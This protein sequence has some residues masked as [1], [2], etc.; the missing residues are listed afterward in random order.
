MSPRE[1]MVSLSPRGRVNVPIP[2]NKSIPSPSAFNVNFPFFTESPSIVTLGSISI[3]VFILSVLFVLFVL[4]VEFKYA[5]YA[6][7]S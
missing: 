5:S 4:F 2:S 7:L 1:P 6:A 3:F